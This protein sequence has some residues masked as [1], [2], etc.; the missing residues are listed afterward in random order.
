MKEFKFD[1]EKLVWTEFAGNMYQI[2]HECTIGDSLSLI[3]IQTHLDCSPYVGDFELEQITLK[4]DQ[5]I[6]FVKDMCVDKLEAFIN[7]TLKLGSFE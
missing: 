1:R 7:E 3:I 2:K 4:K 5:S 6:E